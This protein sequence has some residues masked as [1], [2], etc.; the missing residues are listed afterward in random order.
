[1]SDLGT[2]AFDNSEKIDILIKENFNVSSTNENTPWYLENNATFNTYSN[3]K[4]ILLDEIPNSV[5]WSTSSFL[6]TSQL[7][8][9]YGLTSSDF[10]SGG[11]VK[12]DPSGV[13]HKFIK[14]KL[15][16]IPGATI[17]SG[18]I[19]TYYSYYH[20][21]N[22]VNL[23]QDSFQLNH[24]DG[25]SFAYSMYSNSGI[26][27]NVS[28]L[29]DS[30]GGNW[31][32]N[33]KNGI[34]FVPDPTKNST[35]LNNVNENNLPYFTFVKYV[36]RKGIAKQLAV[37]NSTSDVSDAEAN[38]I[39]VQTSDNTIHRY[40]GSNWVGIGGSGGGSSGGSSLLT[41]DDEN[42]KIFEAGNK[43][44]VTTADFSNSE[45]QTL[46]TPKELYVFKLKDNSGLPNSEL[47]VDIQPDTLSDT[48]DNTFADSSGVGVKNYAYAY[49]N[50]H[51]KINN[52]HQSFKVKI[53]IEIIDPG[54]QRFYAGL[55]GRFAKD[56]FFGSN[57]DVR[58]DNK[59]SFNYNLALA[60]YAG[61]SYVGEKTYESTIQG[62]NPPKLI[63]GV[64]E[65][66]DPGTSMIYILFLLNHSSSSS[67]QITYIKS[68]EIESNQRMY[69][70]Y[71]EAVINDTT[72]LNRSFIN[73]D[74]IISRDRSINIF[75]SDIKTGPVT[76]DGYKN[77]NISKYDNLI[78][79]GD[80]EIK[81]TGLN[82]LHY[83]SLISHNLD[84]RS[85]ANKIR[86][87]SCGE[88]FV[89]FI[90]NTGKVLTF[91][92][93]QFGELGNG[94]TGTDQNKPVEV[95]EANGY[96]KTNAIMVSCGR[97]Y[98]AILLDTGKV[99]TF[100]HNGFGQLGNGTGT[101][102]HSNSPVDVSGVNGYDGTNAVMVSCGDY[103]TAILL[104]T[105]KVLTFGKN[106][107]G[108]LG[109]NTEV[110]K[111]T[112]V[113][114]V[115]SSNGYNKTNAVMVSCGGEHTTI[116]LDSGKVL[117]FGYNSYGQLGNT[118]NFQSADAN[119]S[120][121]E[122]N[123]SG[124]DYNGTN[125]IMVSCG[126]RHTAILL[127]SGK[128]L[129]FG[130]NYYGQLGNGHTN[131]NY[132]PDSVTTANDGYDE[133][134]AV[135]ISCSVHNTA[136]LLS[137]GKVLTFGR[138][139]F[140]QLGN[141][142]SGDANNSSSPVDVSGANGYDKTNAVIISCGWE[143]TAIL[144]NTGK[145]LTF[146]RN[147]YGQLG[148]GDSS[149]STKTS[150]VQVSTSLS[151]D[152]YF[153]DNAY[154][155]AD[156]TKLKFNSKS[157][158]ITSDG[159]LNLSAN[160]VG[161]GTTEPTTDLDVNGAVQI[162]NHLYMRDMPS[163]D[164]SSTQRIIYFDRIDENGYVNIP[165]RTIIGEILFRINENDNY[166]PQNIPN[167][168]DYCAIRGELSNNGSTL[169]GKIQ[170]GLSFWTRPGENDVIKTRMLINHEGNTT[171]YGNLL[172]TDENMGL[173]R[174]NSSEL[175]IKT[176]IKLLGYGDYHNK[177]DGK[178]NINSSEINIKKGDD[179]RKSYY[180]SLLSYNLSTRAFANRIKTISCGHFH[181]AI[182]LNTGNVLTFGYNKY[183]QLGNLTNSGNS[184]PNNS[185]LEVTSANG[186]NG[187]NA[188]MV[189]C[190]LYHTAI[191]L[192]TGKVLT[193]GYNFQGQLGIS[194]NVGTVDAN[195]SPL[196]V[197]DPSGIYDKTNA[198]M[199]SCGSYHTAILLNNGKVLTSGFNN[200]GQ[201]GN[202]TNSG[203]N[204]ANSS[205]LEVTSANGYNKTNAVMVSCGMYHTAIL[206]NTGKV[207]TFGHNQF[208]QLGN[209]TNVDENPS[210]NNS[211]L[212]VTSANGY[213]GTN[214]I[215]VS[216]GSYHTAILLNNG[217]V[218]TFGRN[219]DGELGNGASNA[220]ANSSPL[221]VTSTS[222]YDRSNCVMVSC[223][224]AH[225]AILLDNGKVLT[226]GYNVYGQLGNSNSGHGNNANTPVEVT[227][228]NGYDK[229]DA[230]MISCGGEHTTILLNTGK[231][232]IFGRNQYG[233]L[234]SEE[235]NT[236]ANNS[237]L[238][239]VSANGYDKT[240]AF[241]KEDLII[242][243]KFGDENMG[244]TKENSSEL[245]IKTGISDKLLGY[246]DYYDGEYGK[247]IVNSSEINI[248]KDDL[249]KSYYNSL[250]SY[251][252]STRA[253]ANRI[254]T[255]SCG[256]N[257]TAILLNTGK[258]LTFGSNSFGQLGNGTNV[259][260]NTPVK[261][262]D[263]SGIYDGTNAI[264]V[265][266]G[267]IHTAILL[268]TGKV[269]TFGYN[270]YGQ[271]G[272]SLS[273]NNNNSNTP[274][275]VSEA[276]GY[277]KKNAI[278]VSCGQYYTAILLNTGKVLTFGR[279]EFGQLGNGN[280]GTNQN[281][282]VEVTDPSGIYDGTNAVMVSC[283]WY[284]TAILL[285][286]GK[287]LTFGYNEYGGL[288][289]GTSNNGA[290]GSPF[291][292]INASGYDKTNAVMVSC[293]RRHT[294]ILLNN[295]KVLTFGYNGFGQLGVG[296][297]NINI[298][299]S[300]LEVSIANGYDKTNAVMISC[301]SDYISILLNN[302][303]LL[304]FG[305]NGF[306]ELGNGNSGTNQNKPVEVNSA[307]G[308][309][310]TNTVMVSCGTY[311]TAIL[312]NT[313]KVLTFGRNQFG[314]LGNGNTGTNQNKP[315]EVSEANGYDKTN[316]FYKEDLIIDLNF[317][318]ENMG[319]TRE[320]SSELTIKTGRSDKLLGY[321]DYYDGEDGKLIV[322]G[323]LE[324][325]NNGLYQSYYNSL[326]SY[327]LSTRAF[328]NK[329]KTIGCGVSHTVILLNTGKVLTFGSNTYGQLGNPTNSGIY[330]GSGRVNFSPLEVSEVNGYD[331][332]NAVMVSCGGDH[333]AI[334]LNTGKVLTFGK[335][336][337][338]QLG[339]ST[340]SGTDTANNSPLGVSEV[341][342]YD[343]TNA[344]M[345][346]CGP[347]HTAIL[348]NTGKVL[349]FGRNNYGQ[350]GD[351][352]NSGTNTANNSPLGVSEAN[353]NG[354]DGTN[355]VMV[356][357]GGD[358]TAILLNTG[359][360]LTFGTN[361]YGQLGNSTNLANFNANNSPQAVVNG[362]GYDGT[363]AIMVSC[364]S[365][366]T[367][368]LLN[369]GKVL[370][371][372]YNYYG[373]LG[374][375]I[376][377]RTNTA[378]GSPLEVTSANEYDG[379]NAVMVNCGW[380]HTAILLN[381][382]KVLTS[383]YNRY[384][385]LGDSTNSGTDSAN[386]SLLKVSEV[387]GYDGTNAVMVSCG[388]NHTAILLNNGKVLTLGYN[389]NGQLGNSTN[390]GQ[391]I[392][393]NSPLQVTNANGYNKTNVFY[394]KNHITAD[395]ATIGYI[396]E[397]IAGN[398][399]SNGTITIGDVTI[400]NTPSSYGQ[401]Q[402]T[403]GSTGGY[404]GIQFPGHSSRPTIMARTSDGITGLYYQAY[405]DWAWLCYANNGSPD[406]RLYYNGS[407]KLKTT[408]SGVQVNGTVSTN[409]DRRIKEN[410]REVPDNLSLQKLRDINCVYYE[411][412]D[413]EDRGD[414][415]TI[416]FIAQQVREHI[417][418]AT[419]VITEFIPNEMRVL[420][421]YSWSSILIDNSDNLI[422]NSDNLIVSN[423]YK[424]TI[425]DLSDNSGNQL[426][427]FF[428]S[429]DP[430]GNNETKL[431]IKSLEN[432]PKSF[433]F[434]QSWNYI[435]LYGKE[436][437]DFHTLNKS[438][439]FTLN[440]SA[441]QEIDRIQQ[442][443]KTKVE[444]LE[445]EVASLKTEITEL[446]QLVQDLLNK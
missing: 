298:N 334:L 213:N 405:S 424:L 393:N 103:H 192:N 177:E 121:L 63:D 197:T 246:E 17:T 52:E 61:T 223:G 29:Q 294:A 138:N 224:N 318:D 383:G 198:I 430:S 166:I 291:E 381:N 404:E 84:E 36:G 392:A 126:W 189:S 296:A 345:V 158:N 410:I 375:S 101:N 340:N 179:L 128:V 203:N 27:N 353:G 21:K 47:V 75:D 248:K 219:N 151:G 218:L 175:T 428:V 285:D 426:Y 104:D 354:Y 390:S 3:G 119:K 60:Q 70:V 290:N 85:F 20:I 19:T 65:K 237:P 320:N 23:L 169:G 200:Y 262:T 131:S 64:V 431:E 16:G 212:E 444:A 411:Y 315:V 66:F 388:W 240:N 301:G 370:T 130:Y 356:S 274:V 41:L 399:T 195:N 241:Y 93:N 134:N 178:L 230:V 280:S 348:L 409:S 330:A 110:G 26:A 50:P 210:V 160:N 415:S 306:G 163:T 417:P 196:E 349:T 43:I 302:G 225:T 413:K 227:N 382:G 129:T 289:N 445:I 292:V 338:G 127:D 188:I 69:Q 174:E 211:P 235:A 260:N 216:C 266:C 369:T 13:L 190:G 271:L 46:T 422:D 5:N 205:L 76:I 312:L 244:L 384:G 98:T 148:N 277:D 263:P 406:I 360:V 28:I 324:L 331:G 377:S 193:F 90:L 366:H 185:P 39:V 347:Y 42:I 261:V 427:R 343:G 323:D 367:A 12:V 152:G 376:N 18:S 58:S 351:S 228:A 10:Y 215:M 32:F 137:S 206:L 118:T 332:T 371:F 254:K 252:L 272:N 317:E 199:V 313:G 71:K 421:D 314:E 207:L 147:Q 233:Q 186:Y 105:G 365:E 135:M 270:S 4:D 125:A 122:V 243:L 304:T 394:K 68:I 120:P 57:K 287:V 327:D 67:G 275:E 379:T 293:G 31:F 220:N 44:T 443:E 395:N 171:L 209:T 108:Q 253:F 408:S 256:F 9:I 387:N 326:L 442:Q 378:R 297:S 144:L 201:L 88:Y 441:T 429:D 398:I 362:A 355:A 257:Y 342:G 124:N 433:L 81:N 247:L 117:T 181:T 281:K 299:S 311:H 87:I 423:K 72:I 164:T 102:D 359:K 350:L 238:E 309:D 268:N 434:D 51:I 438:K 316:A 269:L 157:G 221:E 11:G 38:Q 176:G 265:S 346:S 115:S 325:Q 401:I 300:P 361:Y 168:E 143:H 251:N 283:G 385:Q 222:G 229:K 150:P 161:I 255:I 436:V 59:N 273:G 418:M 440:F 37:K 344:V 368:I 226:F 140:G 109:D 337:Y 15:Q 155:S 56:D 437:N 336:N 414:D 100:G 73:K 78:L 99:L 95:S 82:S 35:M 96:N 217:K 231:L 7:S 435:F 310:K 167:F 116:L 34:V 397:V 106:Q 329:I 33:F 111:T 400:N 319:L 425:H 239:V 97:Y 202:I 374:N 55:N 14:L 162:R 308:Y 136:I 341:N 446:K 403:G 145:L 234:G 373:Q 24:G 153:G 112:P 322:I 363:N 48:S 282:P 54:N 62:F 259:S 156:A 77:Y 8:S 284:H 352:T 258:V 53:T 328:A 113:E 264:M 420:N 6:T 40:D 295:G 242:D 133:T 412:K 172:I 89:A 419:H 276:N 333:A 30:N 416:G 432:D 22:G 25:S 236:N 139:Q 86:T 307:N 142:L 80:I 245:T 288:G 214:A 279:N 94:N 208:G 83:E 74:T 380:G 204:N 389:Y 182:L 49:F 187:T 45:R 286:S 159:I 114:V 170:G 183:G 132:L 396:T 2:T 391:A 303:K 91:G 180:N 278:M 372:G 267:E 149:G 232:L 107:Y 357:C 358:H 249:R 1:M 79:N 386:N 154:Y 191:L 92:R 402:I 305:Y 123:T 339:D 173:T 146:G 194:T 335:N 439:L 364:G 250:L 141:D 184:N 165:D 321:E 407:E